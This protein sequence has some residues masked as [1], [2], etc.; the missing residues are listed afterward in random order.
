MSW[1]EFERGCWEIQQKLV[2]EYC[3]VSIL[4]FK[5]IYGVPRGG[6]CIAV[7]LSHLLGLPVITDEK[8]I[9]DYTLIVDDIA[10]TGK[11]LNRLLKKHPKCITATLYFHKQSMIMPD[12]WIY[13][14]KNKWIIFPWEDGFT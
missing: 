7:K 8:K 13:K 4:K 6:L 12:I 14:K 11:T 1:K 9:T 2:E 3:P 5:N 10:E